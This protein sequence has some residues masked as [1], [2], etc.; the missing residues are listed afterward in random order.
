MFGR[1][2]DVD[3]NSKRKENI[4]QTEVRGQKVVEQSSYSPNKQQA[5]H[6]VWPVLF[7]PSFTRL[8]ASGG[9]GGLVSVKV[10]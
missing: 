10:F 3:K 4:E 5:Q 1:E 7:R 6:V 8:M 9:F 2:K